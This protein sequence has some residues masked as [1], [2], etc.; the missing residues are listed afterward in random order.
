M[1]Y[2]F[3][4][5]LLFILLIGFSASAFAQDKPFW[6]DI[7]KFKQQDSLH[8]PAKNGILFVGS[9][10]FT[11]W[12]DLE[13]IF[14]DYN[15]INRGFGGST[16]EQANMYINDLVFPYHPR[17]IVIYSGENDIASGVSAAETFTR[18]KTFYHNIRTK[19]PKVSLIYL[20][21]K[22][23]PSRA[24]FA[25]EIAQANA[26]IKSFLEKQKNSRFIDVN[27]PMLD[28]SGS[29]RPELFKEDQLH[30][31]QA[32]YDIWIKALKPYLNKK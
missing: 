11:Y 14:K 17:Q 9:S 12:N 22:Q 10:S 19:L 15:A 4:F 3:S 28:A 25:G 30:M 32:G 13:T 31:K 20:S 7:Q 23:S 2:N 18:F 26:L 24:K 27:K 21:M 1:K 16:L 6:N 29:P 5:R 8:M